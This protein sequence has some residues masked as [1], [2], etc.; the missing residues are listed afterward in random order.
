MRSGLVPAWLMLVAGC[1]YVAIPGEPPKKDSEIGKLA[2]SC[3]LVRYCG[4]L[5]YVDCGSAVDGPAY[6]FERSSGRVL[7]YCGGYCMGGPCT[8][9]SPA[10]WTCN[11]PVL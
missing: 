10:G 6:Y 5:G 3:K 7:G 8:N 11:S 9:C 2:K 4:K 1:G